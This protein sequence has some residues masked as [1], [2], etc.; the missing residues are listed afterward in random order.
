MGKFVPVGSGSIVSS[1]LGI[2]P[3]SLFLEEVLEFD[4]LSSV[5]LGFL[6]VLLDDVVIVVDLRLEG[7]SSLSEGVSL[8]SK[9]SKFFG[10][11]SSFS[12][13]PTS[14]SGSGGSDLVLE[15][16]QEGGDLSEKLWVVG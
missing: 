14:I 6:G 5:H 9:I 10:P 7:V 15:S 8:S 12:V 16:G 13:F 2:A 4:G 1:L 11:S 3:G